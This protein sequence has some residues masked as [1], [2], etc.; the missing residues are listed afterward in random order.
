[1]RLA[2]PREALLVLIGPAG[3]GKSTFA[4]RHF[5]RTQVVSS[6]ECRALVSDDPTNNNASPDA[7]ALMH[8]IIDKRLKRGLVTVADATN[9]QT[10]RRQQLLALASRHGRPCV[11]L[12]FDLPPALCQ[13][14]NSG[15]TERRVPPAAVLAHA[16]QLRDALPGLRAEGFSEVYVFNSPEAVASAEAVYG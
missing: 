9:V 6:D 8:F 10:D 13:A 3:C 15:R 7:F 5:S 2:I 1:M 14:R 11:A 16:R 12:V 4:A